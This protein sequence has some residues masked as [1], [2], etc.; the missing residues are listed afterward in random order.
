MGAR[1][2]VP[3]SGKSS[4]GSVRGSSSCGAIR[5]G[6]RRTSGEKSERRGASWIASTREL[7][8]ALTLGL[9]IGAGFWALIAAGAAAA[10]LFG[11]EGTAALKLAVLAASLVA[12]SARSATYS[13]LERDLRYRPLA[14]AELSEA[15]AYQVVAVG[16]A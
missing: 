8:T 7:D 9:G 11:L 1:R 15:I 2:P 6:S 16:M 3:Q 12:L 13:Q 4:F 5:R 10:T 14:V